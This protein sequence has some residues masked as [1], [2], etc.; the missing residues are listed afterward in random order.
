MQNFLKT[1][2]KNQ[3]LELLRLLVFLMYQCIV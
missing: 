1:D 3:R 2:Q